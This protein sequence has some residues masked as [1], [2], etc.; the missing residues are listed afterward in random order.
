MYYFSYVIFRNF[1]HLTVKS[2]DL[3]LFNFRTVRTKGWGVLY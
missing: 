3:N 2:C 1:R